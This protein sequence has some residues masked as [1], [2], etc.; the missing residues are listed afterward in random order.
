M[1]GAPTRRE[2]G[3]S[4]WFFACLARNVCRESRHKTCF[5]RGVPCNDCYRAVPTLL[6][7]DDDKRILQALQV[8]FEEEGYE[9]LLASDGQA[10]ASIVAMH[11]PDLI[12]TDWMMPR[13]DGVEFCRTL[14]S[15]ANTRAIPIIMLSAA[16]PPTGSQP[17][18]DVLLHKPVGAMQL[19]EVARRLLPGSAAH[20]GPDG[21]QVKANQRPDDMRQPNRP[22][23]R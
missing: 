20:K 10:G 19:L 4:Q 2:H 5:D 21:Q 3:R 7:V 11:R 12:L 1:D 18:W 16:L 9:V 22:S 13:V 6:L 14:K 23:H 8:L 15:S 17:L